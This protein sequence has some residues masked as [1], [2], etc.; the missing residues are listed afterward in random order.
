ML[1]VGFRLI[2]T[3]QLSGIEERRVWKLVDAAFFALFGDRDKRTDQNDLVTIGETTTVGG[4]I[5]IML[6]KEERDS[7][8]FVCCIF[9][10]SRIV[11]DGVGNFRV[12][13][14]TLLY[15]A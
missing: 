1:F 10:L 2:V 11:C 14:Q 8:N 15:G 4:P 13:E 9:Q 7:L 3:A 5:S 6:W 12:P